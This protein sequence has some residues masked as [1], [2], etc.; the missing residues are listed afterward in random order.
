MLFTTIPV[1]GKQAGLLQ[2]TVPAYKT[3]F[4]KPAEATVIA[5]ND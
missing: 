5:N 2:S 4:T 1:G 3:E